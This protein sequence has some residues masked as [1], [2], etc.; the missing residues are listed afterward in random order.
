MITQHERD[1]MRH[2]LGLHQSRK[3]YRNHFAADP[4]GD[5]DAH[6]QNLMKRGFARLTGV[7]NDVFPYNYY[8]VTATGIEA[9]KPKKIVGEH[10]A[11]NQDEDAL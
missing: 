10:H 9:L 2:A 11:E 1:L 5:D 6:W 7:P 4:N 3:S 8:S